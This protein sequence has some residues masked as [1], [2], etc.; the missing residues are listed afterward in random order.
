MDR[1]RILS[2][3]ILVGFAG[4]AAVALWF[5]L[6]DL[7]AGIPFGPV[8]GAVVDTAIRRDMRSAVAVGMGGAFVDFIYSQLAVLGI[9][10]VLK[11]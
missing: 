8:N 4:A 7:A 9:G 3:G 11:L 6:Y 10:R 2:S 1:A 5:L